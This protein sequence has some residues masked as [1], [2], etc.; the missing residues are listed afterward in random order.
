PGRTCMAEVMTPEPVTIGINE[1]LEQ[2][3]AVMRRYGFRHLPV[4]HQGQL[5]G[6]VSL[7][8]ILLQDGAEKDD[9][10]RMMRA[11]MYSVPDA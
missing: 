1:N 11:Y 2:C 4:C 3:I 6:V 8:D 7:R 9:E 5:V 10:I